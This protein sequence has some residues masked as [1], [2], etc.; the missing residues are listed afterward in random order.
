MQKILLRPLFLTVAMA[1]MWL[2]LLLLVWLQFRSSS[3]LSVAYEQ[4]L[5][6]GLSAAADSFHFDFQSELSILCR[7]VQ[8]LSQNPSA[9]PP[10]SPVPYRMLRFDARDETLS[11]L[12]IDSLRWTKRPWPE[13]WKTLRNELNDTG[14][15]LS[16]AFQRR[17][18]NRPWQA[19]SAVPVLFRAIGG[20]DPLAAGI[21]VNAFWL[22]ELDLPALGTRYFPPSSARSFSVNAIDTRVVVAFLDQVIFDSQPRAP[23]WGHIRSG[24]SCT[25]S[26]FATSELEARA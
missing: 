2:A 21:R 22:I 11:M 18:F 15:A 20:E 14:E 12:D 7:F 8:S 9:S 5:R 4:R 1:T 19:S 13:A 23:F 26:G 24:S 17:W 10:P 25:H 6:S 3:E 16:V